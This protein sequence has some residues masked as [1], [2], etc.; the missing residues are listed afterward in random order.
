MSVQ[1]LRRE[2]SPS[3]TEDTL[4]EVLRKQRESFMN[5]GPPDLAARKQDL[6]RLL[7]MLLDNEARIVAAINEDFGNRSPEESRRLELMPSVLGLRHTL[8]NLRRWMRSQRR[9][10]HW[11]TWPSL[12]RVEHQPLG[13]IGIIAPWN[14]PLYLTIGPLTGALAAGNR[15]MIKPSELTPKTSALLAEILGK[16]FPPEKVTVVNGGPEVAKAFS[17]L[18]FDHLL[19]T[20]SSAVG[21]LVMRAASE[22][23]VPVTLELGGKSPALIGRDYALGGRS[24]DQLVSGKLYNAGQTCVAPDYLLVHE[25][26]QE[27]VIERLR[28]ITA[29]LYPR[30]ADN[31]DFTAI[32]NDRHRERLQGYLRDAADKGATLLEINPGD[33][34]PERFADAG[35]LPLTVLV[36]VDDSGGLR[37]VDTPAALP[38]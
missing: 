30:M 3:V 20:G 6:R 2:S 27:A 33:E 16:T 5:E 31:P 4:R 34:S 11:A 37:D 12:A 35:K 15:A 21:R 7:Q 19:F 22:H 23:L 38:P 18:P 32:I 10:S 36:D 29:G 14:Y 1:A 24:L 26:Q 9:P 17:S 28:S 13:V 8:R 25:S